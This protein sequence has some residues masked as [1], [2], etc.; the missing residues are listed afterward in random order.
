MTK[1]NEELKDLIEKMSFRND[2]E[3]E[4]EWVRRFMGLLEKALCLIEGRLQMLSESQRDSEQYQ[5]IVLLKARLEDAFMQL[6]DPI[7][8]VEADIKAYREEHGTE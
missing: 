4:I 8:G 5:K 7:T 6:K 3:R 2:A 1:F